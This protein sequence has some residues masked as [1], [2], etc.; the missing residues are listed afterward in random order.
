MKNLLSLL[1][2][3]LLLFGCGKDAE[4]DEQQF[5]EPEFLVTPTMFNFEKQGG[6]ALFSCQCTEGKF[7]RCYIDASLA[8]FQFVP[9]KWTGRNQT[10]SVS[11][12]A[13]PFHAAAGGIC[14][15]IYVDYKR[16]NGRT[17]TKCICNLYFRQE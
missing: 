17:V 11:C 4:S 14:G 5:K 12:S 15:S 9:K 10:L 13:L 1:V 16:P 7:E 3:G 8:K 2:C 6:N